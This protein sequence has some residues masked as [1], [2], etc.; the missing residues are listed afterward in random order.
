MARRLTY[1]PLLVNEVKRHFGSILRSNSGGG[2]ESES[3]TQIGSSSCVTNC[4]FTCKFN[5]KDLIVPFHLPIGLIFDSINQIEI[6]QFN[7]TKNILPWSLEFNISKSESELKEKE[8]EYSCAPFEFNNFNTLPDESV[9]SSFY[10]S[11]LKEAD[12]LRSGSAKNVMNLSRTEQLQLWESLKEG[13]ECDKFWRINQKLIGSDF[14]CVRSVPIKFWIYQLSN[15]TLSNTT[16]SKLFCFQF[17]IPISS[18]Q[19]LKLSSL[20]SSEFSDDFLG[21]IKVICLHGLEL[22][23]SISLEELNYNWN[24]ADNFINLLIIIK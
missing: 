9:F 4:W 3:Q 10:F 12:H 5:E 13:G 11:N 16:L 6:N 8:K 14:D 23:L 18:S 7:T 24:Y 21:R 2:D 15:T 17:T 19:N 20:L 22:P 1:F